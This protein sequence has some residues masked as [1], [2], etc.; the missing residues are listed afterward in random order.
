MTKFFK[1]CD[2]QELVNGVMVK[3]FL[4]LSQNDKKLKYENGYCIV[5]I[6]KSRSIANMM[7]LFCCICLFYIFVFI[8]L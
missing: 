7:E 6:L 4:L 8:M 3:I 1:Y 5:T 2:K